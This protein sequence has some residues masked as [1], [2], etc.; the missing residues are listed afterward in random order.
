MKNKIQTFFFVAIII[1]GLFSVGYCNIFDKLFGGK[2]K[3]QTDAQFAVYK[4]VKP[5]FL[6]TLNRGKELSLIDDNILSIAPSQDSPTPTGKKIIPNGFRIQ[7]MA[8]N[9]IE[10]VRARK[11]TIELGLQL[12]VYIVFNEPYYKIFV[13]DYTKRNDA[14]KALRKIKGNGYPDAWIVK[15]K[16]FVDE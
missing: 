5:T 4:Q 11:K 2:E 8:S 3:D 1:S 13:G 16:V 9:S 12:N 7:L 14:E 15:S 10:T 6:D